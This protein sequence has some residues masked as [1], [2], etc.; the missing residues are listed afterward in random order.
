MV[1]LQV[2]KQDIIPDL[3]ILIYQSVEIIYY[4]NNLKNLEY[5]FSENQF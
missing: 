3:E 4:L 2:Y 1:D 5:I